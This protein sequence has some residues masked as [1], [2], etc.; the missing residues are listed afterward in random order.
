VDKL[1]LLGSVL[2]IG[3]LSGVRLY[4]TVLAIGLAVRFGWLPLNGELSSLAVLADTRVLVVAGVLV[5]IEFIADKIPWVDSLW[6]SIHTVVRPLGAA[7]IAFQALGT[8][9]PAVRT[10]FMILSG[11]MALTGHSSKAATRLAVNHSPE[12]FSNIGLSLLEDLF[13]PVALWF[14]LRHPVL[15]LSLLGAFLALFLW[16]APKIFRFLRLELTALVYLIGRFRSPG[17]LRTAATRNIPGLRNSVGLLQGGPE[18]LVFSTRR[19]FRPRT[20]RI[21][22]GDVSAMEWKSGLLLDRLVVR[23]GSTEHSFYVF[24]TAEPRAVIQPP[25]AAVLPRAGGSGW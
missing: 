7:A 22:W 8:A 13:V 20:Y 12:P 10:V 11:T 6:D 21:R 16:L 2:G 25:L 1:A 14:A 24:K 9:D 17:S 15:T 23:V 18:G 19:W 3:F 4:F 5:L